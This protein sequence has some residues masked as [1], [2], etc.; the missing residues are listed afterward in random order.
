MNTNEIF[1]VIIIG[2]GQ[3]GLSTSY[4]LKKNN[5]HHI[6]FE[7][8]QIGNSWHNRWDSFVM[9]SPN[10]FNLLPGQSVNAEDAE[11][12]NTGKQFA[13]GLLQYA[14]T[15][16][17]P[18]KPNTRV[19]SL[20]KSDNENSFLI[21]TENDGETQLWKARQVV[22]ASGGENVPVIPKL[23]H[24]F[25]SSLHQVHVDQYRNPSQLP[26]GG[27]LVIG[28]GTSGVQIAEELLGAGRKVYMATS[29]VARVP[30]RYK[31][32]DVIAWMAD[33]HFFDKPT[34]QAEPFELNMKAP[35][36]S[37]HGDFG[38]T[39]SLQALQ[40]QGAQLFGHLK[41]VENTRI[42]FDNN[43]K[44]TLQFGDGF[45][46][47]VKGGIDQFIAMTGL[48]AEAAEPDEA[49]QPADLSA[50]ENSPISL[51][52]DEHNITSII[53][54]TGFTGD[55]SYIKLPVLNER[56]S[57]IHTDG[58]SPVKHLYF[59]GLPWLRNLKSS[60][61]L[62][63]IGDAEAVSSYVLQNQH[64]NNKVMA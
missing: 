8:G 61:V 49:D 63:S 35:L 43:L 16:N 11:R 20:S 52:L 44:D 30:R 38:H 18:V 14:T 45:S 34:S 24:Q 59:N 17:L 22:V 32:R 56:G 4:L 36:M 9:N 47:Q 50:F 3:A 31:G 6:V 41:Q 19:I 21:E 7:R 2:A 48:Q 42:T 46:A 26:E 58:I 64:E 13:D 60:L 12:F 57:P 10:Q 23:Q 53:W 29:A 54:T 37:G 15:N 51:D 40:K 39:I 27:V 25:P 1:D 55:F 5:I 28:S 33:L 62:G